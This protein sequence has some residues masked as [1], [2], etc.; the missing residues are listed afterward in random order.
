M[1]TSLGR[2]RHHPKPATEPVN[3]LLGGTNHPILQN[4]L[5]ILS[6]LMK[7]PSLVTLISTILQSGNVGDVVTQILHFLNPS[8]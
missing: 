3:A 2:K 1:K 8:A 7:T 4:L 6:A 5:Q